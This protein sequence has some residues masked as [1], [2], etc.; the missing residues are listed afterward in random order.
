M[1]AAMIMAASAAL[2]IKKKSCVRNSNA[3]ITSKPV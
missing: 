3:S 2:G 1:T